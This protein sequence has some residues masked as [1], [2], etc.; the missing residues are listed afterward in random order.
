MKTYMFSLMLEAIFPKAHETILI[1]EKVHLS[2]C[3]SI[4]NLIDGAACVT[5][6]SARNILISIQLGGFKECLRSHIERGKYGPIA[7][8]R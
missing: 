2:C 4:N 8:I 7:L 5:R 3:A 1:Q 6:A